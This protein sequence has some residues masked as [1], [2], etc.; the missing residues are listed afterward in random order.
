MS[1]RTSFSLVLLC[2]I[3][4]AARAQ[5]PFAVKAGEWETTI[6]GQTTG[7]LAVPQEVLDKLTPEQRARAEAAMK[8]RN[9]QPTVYKSCAKKEDLDKPFAKDYHAESC[10]QR[11]LTS[12][13]S[14]QEIH[15]DC[16]IDGGKQAGTLKLEATDPGTVKGTLQMVV[17]NGDRTMNL[18]Y[19]YAAKWLGP[20]CT[21]SK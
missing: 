4:S 14:K 9:G 10:K 20:T 13:P 12:T 6:T 19:L 11:F 7:Q 16:Q 2:V 17:T 1:N 5:S 18:N 15:V 3:A 8:A 21:D